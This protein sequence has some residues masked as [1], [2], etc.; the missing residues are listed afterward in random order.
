MS[1]DCNLS[2]QF[3]GTWPFSSPFEHIALVTSPLAATMADDDSDKDSSHVGCGCFTLLLPKGTC[4]NLMTFG[5][6]SLA[7][8]DH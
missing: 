6:W 3:A 5:K 8:T 1:S 7:Y 2:V 4:V